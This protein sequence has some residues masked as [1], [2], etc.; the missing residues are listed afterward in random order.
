MNGYVFKKPSGNSAGANFQKAVYDNIVNESKLVMVDGQEMG[1]TIQGRT[2]VARGGGR[3]RNGA[4]VATFILL[5]AEANHL[6]CRDVTLSTLASGKIKIASIGTNDIYVAKPADLRCFDTTLPAWATGPAW[7]SM[8]ISHAF[9]TSEPYMVFTTAINFPDSATRPPAQSEPV[10]ANEWGE[11][12]GDYGGGGTR[13][14]LRLNYIRTV[15]IGGIPETQRV[16]PPWRKGELIY[17][18]ELDDS[19]ETDVGQLT[20]DGQSIDYIM[21]AD[22]RQWARI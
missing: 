21:V 8:T 19:G 10:G 3:G 6:V 12:A 9:D 20:A 4:G 18:M 15:T 1:N 11:V 5:Y 14:N 22:G 2:V 13:S 17:A 7:D 16:I